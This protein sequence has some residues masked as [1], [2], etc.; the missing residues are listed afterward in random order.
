MHMLGII[1][2]RYGNLA[3]APEN[4]GRALAIN[5][6]NPE[7][8]FDLAQCARPGPQPRRDRAPGRSH[9]APARL[10]RGARIARGML[11]G[12]ASSTPRCRTTSRCSPPIRGRWTPATPGQLAA[13][14]GRL[15]ERGRAI[16]AGRCAPAG[17]RG[18]PQQSRRRLCNPGPFRKPPA[19]LPAGAVAQAR[20]GRQLP[21]P[22]HQ[23]GQA[24]G[25]S[26]TR[27]LAVIMRGWRLRKPTKRKPPLCNAR[28]G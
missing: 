24:I 28:R 13:A 9:G 16:P 1:A 27:R 19:I 12:R 25:Q 2:T 11:A 18:G 14:A 23:R 26:R 15:D 3:G 4:Y 21:Q 7:C 20:T 17:L 22:G 10:C 8:H 6:R 5:G